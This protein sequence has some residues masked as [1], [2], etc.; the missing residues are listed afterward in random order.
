MIPNRRIFIKRGDLIKSWP[1]SPLKQS[2]N[3][4]EDIC[5]DLS[6]ITPFGNIPQKNKDEAGNESVIGRGPVRNPLFADYGE[7]LRKLPS[8]RGGTKVRLPRR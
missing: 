4:A 3:L 7:P 1:T 6:E 8:K 5:K 2:P